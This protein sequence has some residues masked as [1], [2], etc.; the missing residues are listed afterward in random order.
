MHLS[1]VCPSTCWGGGG[2]LG[3][4][5]RDWG[6]GHSTGSGTAISS[7]SIPWWCNLLFTEVY[8]MHMAH[9]VYIMAGETNSAV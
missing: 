6:D 9:M 3:A 5:V 8:R 4:G 1:I 7:P 2:G